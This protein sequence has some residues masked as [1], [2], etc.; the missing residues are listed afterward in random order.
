M[1]TFLLSAAFIF[2]LFSS[3]VFADPCHLPCVNRGFRSGYCKLITGANELRDYFRGRNV[4]P[5]GYTS[6]GQKPGCT[7]SLLSF[8]F[9]VCCCKRYN[10]TQPICTP[11]T[12]RCSQDDA[13]K[14][15][16]R[17]RWQL[18]EQCGPNEECRMVGTIARCVRVSTT[19]QPSSTSPMSIPRRI[20]G[21]GRRIRVL[22][23]GIVSD[24]IQ[25]IMEIFER[26]R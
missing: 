10:M 1:F 16:E 18:H 7:S 4:C 26:P 12:Y 19:T 24:V 11:G 2:V 13:Y 6:I 25:Y 9:V 21:R 3:L 20:V 5:K 14:C 15:N 22:L 23:A 8:R 17:G